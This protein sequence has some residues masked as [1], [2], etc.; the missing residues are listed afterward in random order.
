[1]ITNWGSGARS[2]VILFAIFL[3][4]WVAVAPAPVRAQE[5]HGQVCGTPI[6][7]KATN[8]VQAV[9]TVDERF[10]IRG[11]VQFN[12]IHGEEVAPINLSCA[13][14]TGVEVKTITVAL[15]VN[16]YDD[17]AI[18]V[19]PENYSFAVNLECTACFTRS[20]ALQANVPMARLHG[21][22]EGR[23]LRH[24]LK[25]LDASLK[26]LEKQA[27]DGAITIDEANSE[28]DQ[29]LARFDEVKSA[30]AALGTSA[31]QVALRATS[32][33]LFRTDP[34]HSAWGGSAPAAGVTRRADF[35]WNLSSAFAA[36]ISAE[37][38]L[39][40]GPTA[41]AFSRA[42]GRNTLA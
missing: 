27:N 39:P 40:F 31:P 9:N 5:G 23:E 20:E 1:M 22:P 24:Q 17:D 18:T 26:D 25:E 30:F 4:A 7:G 28:V 13:E 2:I 38:G 21:D 16:L 14:S 8:D 12:E 36:G 15:Q 3:C 29:I 6:P 10:I 32:G 34:S 42:Q 37:R 19:A 33:S 35:P 11:R 41:S